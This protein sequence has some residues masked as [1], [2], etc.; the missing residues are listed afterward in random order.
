MHSFWV[1]DVD[2]D[3]ARKYL[4]AMNVPEKD[5]D[6]ILSVTGGRVGLL[7]DA[8][9]GRNSNVPATGTTPAMLHAWSLV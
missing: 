8:A 7:Q 6:T 2:L 5:H 3:R 1:S 4:T 9:E